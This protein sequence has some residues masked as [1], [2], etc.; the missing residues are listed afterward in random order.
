[1]TDFTIV[2]EGASRYNFTDRESG[3]VV[4]GV[5]V[6]HLVESEGEDARGKIP[7]K[8]T[9]PIEAWDYIVRYNFPCKCSL[10]TKQI[11]GK[12]GVITKVIGIKEI[13]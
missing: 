3:R 10:V 6:F 1:M 11:L 5:N 8:I 9:L 7:S 13:K 12:K 4:Q 2:V